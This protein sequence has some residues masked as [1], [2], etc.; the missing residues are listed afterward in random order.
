[1][2]ASNS[3]EAEAGDKEAGIKP[4][5]AEKQSLPRRRTE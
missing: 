4:P 5:K 3:A 2:K 1:M